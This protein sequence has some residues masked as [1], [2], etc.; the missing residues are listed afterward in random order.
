MTGKPRGLSLNN[1]LNIKHSKDKWKGRSAYQPDPSLVRFD[2]PEMGL[3]AAARNL[4]TYEENG[5]NTGREDHQAVGA[6]GRSSARG[7]E[8][9]RRIHRVRRQAQRARPRQPAGP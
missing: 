4:L 5:F 6:A 8:P 7:Q 3:R 1:P 2:S 9:D